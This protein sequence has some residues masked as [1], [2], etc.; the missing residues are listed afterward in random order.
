MSEFRQSTHEGSEGLAF[1]EM[2]DVV[3]VGFG[4][5]GGM[6]AIEAHDAG[7]RVLLL[8]KAPDPGGIS[9]CAGGGVRVAF[10]REAALA[11]MNATSAG[12]VPAPVIEMMVDGMMSLEPVFEKLAA[13]NG[14]EIVIR[15]RGG[16]YPFPGHDT[17]G[18]LEVK[19]IPNF[20]PLKE[21][22]FVRGRALGPILFKLVHDNVR[23]RKIEVRLESAVRR[24]VAAPD[25]SARGVVVDIAGKARRIGARRG[26]ILACGGFEAD[27]KMQSKYWQIR[28]VQ[29]AANKTNTGDGIRMAQALGADLWHMWHFHGSYGY[30]HT[31]PAYPYLL[32]IKRLPDWTPTVD[33]PDVPMAWIVIDRGGRRFMNEYHPYSQDTGNRALDV[34]DPV[35]QSF[36]YVPAFLVVDDDGRKMYPLGQAVSNDRTIKPYTWSQDNFQEVENGI[37]AKAD[38][39]E[40]LAAVLGADVQTVKETLE[41]W[42]KGCEAG[43]DADYGRPATTMVPV[44]KPPF[45]VA[46][47]WPLVN[48]TQ[49]GPVHDERQ[50]V[51]N[52]FGEPISRLYVAGELGSVWSFLYLSGGNI[53]ECFITGRIAGTEAAGLPAWDEQPAS[54]AYAGAA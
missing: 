21:Y 43:Q 24:V 27:P 23:S 42:N 18:M 46:R 33:T 3:V 52:T 31:D 12:D 29:S 48:N 51:L 7:S 32:R 20:D 22:P 11:Y 17:L 38:S 34:Y 1:D 53:S 19:S 40:E 50:R 54:G 8:E 15:K 6:A 28:P 36:P 14:A 37:L 5:A 41:R 4:L 26:V 47:I 13:V 49:G 45:F 16:N 39:V 25:G 2:Y 35:T 30:R 44:R 9:I 10:D